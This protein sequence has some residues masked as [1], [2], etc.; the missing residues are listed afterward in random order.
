MMSP[1][2]FKIP[3]HSG[4]D[5]KHKR[6]FANWKKSASGQPTERNIN[7]KRS[8]KYQRAHAQ[9]P[10]EK[11]VFTVISVPVVLAALF[12]FVWMFTSAKTGLENALD[13]TKVTAKKV[14]TEK[15]KAYFF[16]T[17]I[18]ERQLAA[19]DY[20]EARINF[21]QALKFGPYGRN[22]RIGLAKTLDQ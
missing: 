1:C 17:R 21:S 13:K 20:E 7:G 22:A 11:R 12:C 10:F 5:Q 4:T 2:Q 3:G 18:A 16:Y 8:G 19:R 14:H 9:S 6:V 15:E